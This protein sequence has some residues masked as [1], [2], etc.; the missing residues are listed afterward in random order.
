[1]DEKGSMRLF[2][3]L[4]KNWSAPP[5]ALTRDMWRMPLPRVPDSIPYSNSTRLFTYTVGSNYFIISN[6]CSKSVFTTYA[7]W[8][9]GSSFS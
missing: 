8:Q 4:L 9:L 7:A 5:D 6:Y 1:M 2:G 3:Q